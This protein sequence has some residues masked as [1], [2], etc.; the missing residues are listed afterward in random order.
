MTIQGNTLMK[1]NR[2]TVEDQTFPKITKKWTRW[3]L[4]TSLIEDKDSRGY[5]EEKSNL[6]SAHQAR[7]SSHSCRKTA[8][9]VTSNPLSYEPSKD[10]SQNEEISFLNGGYFERVFVFNS[11]QSPKVQWLPHSTFSYPWSLRRLMYVLSEVKRLLS[12]WWTRF[13]ANLLSCGDR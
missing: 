2:Q 4:F 13:V 12:T 6:L 11:S 1:L 7:D 5:A 8:S 10:S 9:P 3:N